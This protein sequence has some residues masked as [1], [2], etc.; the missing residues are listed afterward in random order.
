MSTLN[1]VRIAQELRDLGMVKLSLQVRI[2]PGVFN[3]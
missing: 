2:L 1:E 3:S